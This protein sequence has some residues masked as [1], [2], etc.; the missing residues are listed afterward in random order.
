M[1]TANQ[2]S[3]INQYH[4]RADIFFKRK[5]YDI[6]INYCDQI[7]RI[8]KS[9]D[10]AKKLKL[11]SIVGIIRYYLKKGDCA[12][13]MHFCYTGMSIDKSY[14]PL[15][16]AFLDCCFYEGYE[17]SENYK[18]EILN[19]DDPQLIEYK[20][21]LL[22]MDQGADVA[23]GYLDIEI[24]KN[25]DVFEIYYAKG[26]ALFQQKKFEEA[27]V[28]F[29]KSIQLVNVEIYNP[30][31]Y[32]ALSLSALG[33]KEE[34][35]KILRDIKSHIKEIL[36][37]YSTRS[38][39]KERLPVVYE[40]V[41]ADEQ[42]KF[43]KTITQKGIKRDLNN[44]EYVKYVRY[45]VKKNIY[46]TKKSFLKDNLIFLLLKIKLFRDSIINLFSKKEK[47]NRFSFK[48][49]FL[50]Y[51]KC[52]KTIF[53]MMV[54][55]GGALFLYFFLVVY[56]LIT[57]SI[58]QYIFQEYLSSYNKGGNLDLLVLYIS[59]TLFTIVISSR[60]ILMAVRDG[61][62]KGYINS[63]LKR[64][65]TSKSQKSMIDL[66]SNSLP[67]SLM[68]II[69]NHYK[70]AHFYNKIPK[71]PV[72]VGKIDKYRISKIRKNR[73]IFRYILYLINRVN[74]NLTIIRRKD[75]SFERVQ[76]FAVFCIY[77]IYFF[78][79]LISYIF[80]YGQFD[81][82]YSYFSRNGIDMTFL[83]EALNAIIFSLITFMAYEN[84]RSTRP[85]N[86]SGKKPVSFYP[87]GTDSITKR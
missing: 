58:V 73:N 4:V 52:L 40:L 83:D 20:A 51:K 56:L 47:Q 50:R 31:F 74:L 86:K 33:K 46:S 69:L 44:P 49:Y 68:P 7:L 45:F 59:V 43:N 30:Y 85:E 18:K 13:A 16:V 29:D 53:R 36:D 38:D 57:F 15:V 12:T 41:Y 70:A 87:D 80:K 9:D 76:H 42:S 24:S 10:K 3:K 55:F 72:I 65:E 5:K 21:I 60:H 62:K 34:A 82:V 14:T 8:D 66:Y 77:F 27:I 67:S 32:K 19:F 37:E 2:L 54:T 71:N 39:Y 17:I 48:K 81:F 61:L 84:I 25:S 22:R 35:V 6:V 28:N 75:F 79:I 26:M 11:D 1:A 23:L 64:S 63:Y 78:L